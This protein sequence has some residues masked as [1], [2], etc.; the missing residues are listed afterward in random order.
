MRCADFERRLQQMLDDR[1]EVSLRT[2]Q[3]SPAANAHLAECD[4]CCNLLSGYQILMM[5]LESASRPVQSTGF[6]EKVLVQ[7]PPVREAPVRTS[8]LPSRRR[9]PRQLAAAAAGRTRERRPSRS[10]RAPAA[11]VSR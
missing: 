6:V 2:G 7:S 10:R 1:E 3:L 5:G 11:A 4:D 9:D 8:R